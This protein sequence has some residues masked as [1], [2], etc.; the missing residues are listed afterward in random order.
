MFRRKEDEVIASTSQPQSANPAPNPVQTPFGAPAQKP[1]APS[2][3]TFGAAPAA[4]AT[5]A[6][7]SAEEP[8]KPVTAP[9][10]TQQVGLGTPGA[11]PAQQQTVQR[12]PGQPQSQPQT[13]T[14]AAPAANASTSTAPAGSSF[15]PSYNKVPSPTAAPATIP[16]APA[17]AAAQSSSKLEGIEAERRLTVGYGITL[18]GEVSDC[19]RLVIYGKVNAKLA[20]VKFLQISDS[21]K[22]NGS[23]QIEQAEIS[24]VFE[25]ELKVTNNI[26]ITSTGR[27]NGKITYGAIEI[28]P[29]GK[30]TGEIIEDTSQLH[31]NSG[32]DAGNGQYGLNNGN[33][34]STS[35]KAA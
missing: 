31:Q 25:G 26:T 23:A 24:G 9:L 22:F 11:A 15:A 13:Q 35:D 5:P 10:T 1:A 27:V 16:A 21:G 17:P 32:S 3:G 7:Q 30:F 4:S 20:N 29:G 18:T 19:D 12:A 14:Q 33:S 8:K 2:F 6:A 34:A 28:R